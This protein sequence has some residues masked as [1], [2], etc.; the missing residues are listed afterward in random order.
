MTQVHSPADTECSREFQPGSNFLFLGKNPKRF[1]F[2][3]PYQDSEQFLLLLL[4]REHYAKMENS[5]V[6]I[7][8]FLRSGPFTR[9]QYDL[10][11]RGVHH[12]II[13]RKGAFSVFVPSLRGEE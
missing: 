11:T 13:S 7:L 6:S 2:I 8:A 5:T 3:Y 10:T 1:L 9:G 12:A 4:L